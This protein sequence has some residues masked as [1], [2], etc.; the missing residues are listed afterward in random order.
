M[1]FDTKI[2]SITLEAM[3]VREIGLYLLGLHLC[4]L[5]TWT[6]RAD[7]RYNARMERASE[8]FCKDRC[9]SL[10]HFLYELKGDFVRTRCFVGVKVFEKIFCAFNGYWNVWHLLD[11]FGIKFLELKLAFCKDFQTEG[12]R[13]REVRKKAKIRNRCHQLQNLAQDS[14]WESDKTQ[15]NITQKRAKR[16]ALSLQVI[17]RLQGTDKTVRHRQQEKQITKRIHK[18]ASPWNGQK[19]N[20]WRA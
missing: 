19:E 12:L 20:Y 7:F 8:Y 2:C 9:N 11:I 13:F 14:I 4:F 5:Y 6:P 1:A 18:K 16:S 17:T 15:E 10:V 3:Q